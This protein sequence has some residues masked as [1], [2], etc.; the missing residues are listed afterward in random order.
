MYCDAGK[1]ADIRQEIVGMRCKEIYPDWKNGIIYFL[2]EGALQVVIVCVKN[3][4]YAGID[5][6]PTAERDSN[7]R[8]VNEK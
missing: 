1:L 7:E 8:S 5:I 3:N 6:L 4:Y 2:F